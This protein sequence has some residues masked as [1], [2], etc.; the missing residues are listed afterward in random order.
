MEERVHRFDVTEITRATKTQSNTM[1]TLHR[2][3]ERDK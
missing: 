2:S 3:E 1:G